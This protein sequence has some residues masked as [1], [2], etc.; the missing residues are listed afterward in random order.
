[1]KLTKKQT[2]YIQI[3]RKILMFLFGLVVGISLAFYFKDTHPLLLMFLTSIG[4]IVIPA[5]LYA[6]YF[7]IAS[8]LEPI[9][10]SLWVDFKTWLKE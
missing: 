3:T 5:S 9:C 1:M 2:K 8:F 4:F 10:L 6:L 7:Y